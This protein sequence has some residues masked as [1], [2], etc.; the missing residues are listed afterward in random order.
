MGGSSLVVQWLRLCVST[1]GG[2]GSILG[3]GTKV[4]HAMWCGQKKKNLW[5][6]RG[7]GE[8]LGVGNK[9]T[10]VSVRLHRGSGICVQIKEW[11]SLKNRY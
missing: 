5:E 2:T 7:D 1:T 9:G 3:R 10:G 4:L 6:S 8:P 11:M